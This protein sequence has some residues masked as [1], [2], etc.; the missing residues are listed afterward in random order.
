MTEGEVCRN[1]RWW[2]N[3]MDGKGLCRIEPPIRSDDTGRGEWPET[4]EGDWCGQ[5]ARME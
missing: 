4:L 2:D 3:W 1:C 5:H